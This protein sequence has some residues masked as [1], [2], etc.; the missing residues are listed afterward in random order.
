MENQST[1]PRCFT[2]VMGCCSK[3]G[4]CS[5]KEGSCGCTGKCSCPANCNCKRDDV[6]VY[7]KLG[8]GMSWTMTSA[9]VVLAAAGAVA[10]YMAKNKK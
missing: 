8:G 7:P 9:L 2:L 5:L 4:T 6:R 1:T 3:D 10:V